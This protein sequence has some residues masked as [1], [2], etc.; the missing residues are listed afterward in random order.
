M[1]WIW[2]LLSA[3]RHC[4]EG[5]DPMEVSQPRRRQAWSVNDAW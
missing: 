3:P 1:R 5:I 4:V 2:S